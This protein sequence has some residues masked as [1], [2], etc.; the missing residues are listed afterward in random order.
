[1]IECPSCKSQQFVGTIYCTECGN[2]LVHIS[3]ISDTPP[4]NVKDKKK[5]TA[6][7]SIPGPSLQTGA[8]LGLKVVGSDSVV[9]LRGRVNYTLGRAIEDQAVIPDIDLSPFG[10]E[11]YGVSRIHA[12]VLLKPDGIFII[13]LDSANG[14]KVNGTQI[15]TVTPVHLRHGDI[16]QLGGLSVQLIS[17]FHK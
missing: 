12:E 11:K 14:T 15:E 5:K 4:A 16:I 1:M 8:L 2:R 10:A 7:S 6:P 9:S 13:D 3:D 17:R